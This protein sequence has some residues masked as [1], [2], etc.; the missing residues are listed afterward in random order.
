MVEAAL[1]LAEIAQRF[2]VRLTPNNNDG[3]SV[4]VSAFLDGLP[5]KRHR[6]FYTKSRIDDSVVFIDDTCFCFYELLPC[7]QSPRKVDPL[8][9]SEMR[10]TKAPSYN[11]GILLL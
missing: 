8:V 11:N 4:A 10:S 2:R 6:R 9:S 3:L 5:A 1:L 7:P